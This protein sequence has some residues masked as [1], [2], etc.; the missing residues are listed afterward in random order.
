MPKQIVIRDAT[1]NIINIGPWD[2]QKKP[3][4]G[5]DLEKP[6]NK[7]VRGKKKTVYQQKVVGHQV[8]NPLPNGATQAEEEVVERDDGG[9]AAA[10]DYASLRRGAYP[11]LIDQ[12][13]A[14][15]KGGPETEAM[16]ARIQAVKERYPKPV[17]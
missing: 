15:W 12:L 4:Y 17:K 14:L 13:D 9:L 10:T 3:I 16:R 2:E 11:S 8:T 6:I 7:I 1:G 5:D